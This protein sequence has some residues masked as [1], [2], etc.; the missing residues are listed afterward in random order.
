MSIYSLLSADSSVTAIT[1]NIYIGQAPQGSTAPYIVIDTIFINPQ[2]LMSERTTTDNKRMSVDCYGITQAQS[3]ALYQA[4][5]TAL[6][7]DT[8]ILNVNIYGLRDPDIDI[9]R[10]QFDVSEWVNV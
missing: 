6:E 10:T 3:V 7:L 9:F 5:R 1:T 8:H 2:N 4:C